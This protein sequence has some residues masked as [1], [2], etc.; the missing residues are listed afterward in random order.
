MKKAPQEMGERTGELKY[1]E[2]D[3]G[4]GGKT[5]RFIQ[6]WKQIGKEDFINTEFYQRI[7]DQNGA[8]YL[9]VVD[10]DLSVVE[11]TSD[12][13][14]VVY[15]KGGVYGVVTLPMHVRD[16][17]KVFV[18]VNLTDIKQLNNIPAE[19]LRFRE[20]ELSFKQ[21]TRDEVGKEKPIQTGATTHHPE[22]HKIIGPFEIV[23]ESGTFQK[24]EIIVLL[25]ENGTE[26]TTFLNLIAVA[27]N[28]GVEVPRLSISFKPQHLSV[29]QSN[30]SIYPSVYQQPIQY[31]GMNQSASSP[32]LGQIVTKENQSSNQNAQQTTGKEVKGSGKDKLTQQ[33]KA[34]LIE[35]ERIEKEKIE[36]EKDKEKERE[37]EREASHISVVKAR[38]TY[39]CY[40]ITIIKNEDFPATFTQHALETGNPFVTQTKINLRLER[41]AP[42]PL[43]NSRTVSKLTGPTTPSDSLKQMDHSSKQWTR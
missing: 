13:V 11:Y 36:K 42:R 34:A 26:K 4:M 5:K 12:I 37:R 28:G 2:K 6:A 40:N 1:K 35:K 22:I 33:E 3:N 29:Y 9:F 19:N 21:Q 31:D 7:K 32:P 8:D 25:G 16:E 41:P 23:C 18:Q 27:V 43:A 14:N 10:H 39:F 15:G 17:V 30:P 24:G 20:Y 38:I